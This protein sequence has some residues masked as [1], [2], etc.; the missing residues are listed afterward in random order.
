MEQE[1]FNNNMDLTYF[2]LHKY[3]PWYANDEDAKQI[4]LIGLWKACEKFD[5]NKGYAFSTFA[6]RVI[7]NQMRMFLRDV[8]KRNRIKYVDNIT[9]FE[10]EELDILEAI[11]DKYEGEVSLGFCFKELSGKL[12]EKETQVLQMKI[13]GYNQ[14]EIAK[15]LNT[16]QPTVARC[17]Q[18]IVS[19]L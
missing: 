8:R 4:C 3:F 16:S 9:Y 1:L 19:K 13:K 10:G 14:N 7:L 18:R 6:A 12:T 5:P 2:L 11:P 15:K 17:L